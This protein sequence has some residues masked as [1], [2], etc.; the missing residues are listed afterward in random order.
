MFKIT[1][2]AMRLGTNISRAS[3]PG[4]QTSSI[5]GGKVRLVSAPKKSLGTIGKIK[6]QTKQTSTYG[7]NNSG[8]TKTP[9]VKPGGVQ[10][11]TQKNIGVIENTAKMNL[12]KRDAKHIQ[13]GIDPG[14]LAPRQ[15]AQARILVKLRNAT[16]NNND[17]IASAKINPYKI[18]EENNFYNVP[19]GLAPAKTTITEKGLEYLGPHLVK[20]AGEL[21]TR[22]DKIKWIEDRN[23]RKKKEKIV[24]G[25][26][27][28]F[29]AITGLVALYRTGKAINEHFKKKERKIDRT[30]QKAE[31][32]ISA[33]RL[34]GYAGSLFLADQLRR[35]GVKNAKN[36][37]D[38]LR[39]NANIDVEDEETS[40][41]AL[42]LNNNKKET[43][44]DI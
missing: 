5:G 39:R 11:V 10:N 38:I 33:L 30:I 32:G 8:Q 3:A 26:G 9:A 41:D 18:K 7:V 29:K 35:A 28:A 27:T 25:I 14:D 23:K 6:T 2:L 15:H 42:K 1:K 4:A 37:V 20:A 44:N 16:L 19:L 13:D 34:T 24:G 21:K 43:R 40:K 22:A 31:A 36:K 17:K 12:Q